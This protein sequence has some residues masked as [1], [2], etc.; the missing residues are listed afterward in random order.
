MLK[1]RKILLCNYLYYLIL[2]LAIFYCTVVINTNKIDLNKNTFKGTI[3]KIIKKDNDIIYTN[4]NLIV[5]LNKKNKFKVG[6]NI[7]IKGSIINTLNNTIYIKPSSI[8]YLSTS[9]NIIYFIK[10]LLIKRLKNNSYLYTFILGDKSY[11]NSIVKRSYQENGIS[12]LFAISGMHISLLSSIINKILKRTSIQEETIFKITSLF[13]LLYLFIVGL[14]PSILRGVLFYILFTTNNI[15][16]FYIKKINLFFLIVSISLFINPYSIFDIGYQYSY[17]ISF[18]LLLNNNYLKSNNY[19]ISLFKVSILSSI[20]SLPISL[21]HFYQINILSTIYNLFF[22]PLVSIIV[23]P[24]S[25]IVVLFPI[26]EPIYNEVIK[27]LEKT[28]LFLVN[29]NIGK[30]IFKKVNIIIY[31]I[32]ILIII[33]FFIFRKKIILGI[34]IFILIFHYH[35]PCF[36]NYFI[37]YIDVGQGD[38]TLIHLNNKNIMI[39]TG[40]KANND[41][42]LLY[43]IINELKKEGIKKIDYLIS[44]HGDFDHIGEAINL[45]EN[46]KVEKVIFNCGSYNDLE[47]ELIKV[48]DKKKIKYYS[49]IKELNIDNN[50]LYFLQTKEYDNENDN[51]NV[52]YTELDG[53]KFIFMGD[54]S[55]STEKEIMDK[56]NLPDIDVLKIGHHGSKTSSSQEFI[57]KIQPKYSIISVGKNNRYGHPNKEVLDNLKDTKIYRTDE[58]GS[59]MFNIKNNKLKIETCTP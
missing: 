7:L 5:Y 14:S 18:S 20:V 49:C 40:G 38:C 10:R 6:D 55:T 56:Y 43:K 1:L 8:K 34:L 58:D 13:L 51:S 19:F 39:D 27:V 41:L 46:F 29:I 52:I 3:T 48:L 50:K 31:L 47:N 15:Y 37:K 59:I 25:L 26:T 22:V 54:A 42:V 33:L 4:N 53:Y 57:N 32:Y 28:S 45:V 16:Y 35:L 2:L 30:L 36:M 17:L 9:P 21:Y 24:F 23:F 11:I 12:H 44:S